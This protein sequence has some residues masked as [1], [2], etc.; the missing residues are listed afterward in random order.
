MSTG[1][2]EAEAEAEAGAD[3]GEEGVR[4][5]LTTLEDMPALQQ[6]LSPPDVWRALR[7]R[8]PPSLLLCRV[9]FR[10]GA[11]PTFLIHRVPGGEVIGFFIAYGRFAP[12]AVL[13]FDGG[14]TRGGD[15]GRGLGR[16]SL[17]QFMELMFGAQ[18]CRELYALV[19]QDNTPC[20]ELLKVCGFTI[21]PPTMRVISREGPQIPSVEAVQTIREWRDWRVSQAGS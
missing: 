14:L 15:R 6:A 11:V 10:G 4:V 19:A 9:T 20:I 8:G 17:T 5:R 21:R 12:E 3:P 16:K 2:D 18:R 13:E 7:F 1:H